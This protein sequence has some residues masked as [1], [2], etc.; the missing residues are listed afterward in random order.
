[1]TLTPDEIAIFK[2]MSE[3]FSDVMSNAGSNDFRLPEDWS[4]MKRKMWALKTARSSMSEKD[5]QEY[6]EYL[7]NVED[8]P[9]IFDFF[10]WRY[11]VDTIVAEAERPKFE[12]VY[13]VW[14]KD[15]KYYG[16][17]TDSVEASDIS[18][19]LNGRMHAVG[20]TL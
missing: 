11:L 1:M 17:Y 6:V 10:V 13:I 9:V 8:A 18:I 14:D 2:Q 7:R 15:N 12:K 5:Y 3:T 20:D 19:W 4:P 16:T